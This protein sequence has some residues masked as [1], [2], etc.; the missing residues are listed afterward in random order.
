M[1]ELHLEYHTC[2]LRDLRVS[3]Y[4]VSIVF[5][6]SINVIQEISLRLLFHSVLNIF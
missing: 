2:N 5:S 6:Y 4:S 1:D 3:F